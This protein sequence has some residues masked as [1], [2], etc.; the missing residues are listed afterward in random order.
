MRHRTNTFEVKA[1]RKA[2]E[3][4]PKVKARKKAYYQ[5]P[6]VKAR[7]KAY[8]QTPEARRK[9]KQYNSSKRVKL[10]RKEYAKKPKVKAYAK[11]YYQ[12]PQVV[13]NKKSYRKRD[14][15]R[16]KT[17]DYTRRPEVNI[18]IR[19]RAILNHILK[20]YTLTGKFQSSRKY[21]INFEEIIKRLKPFPAD[22]SK[23][24]IDHIRPLCNFNFIN[25][26]GTQNLEEIKKAFA[27]ENHQWLL[28]FDNLSKGSKIIVQQELRL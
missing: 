25:K 11:A 10:Y 13:K 14:Y 22:I 16:K 6:E 28:A 18:R 26:D 27:P 20:H 24:H 8:Y 2:Y 9:F 4:T 21:G 5:N 7:R 19:I 12:N 3:Q 15:V 23:Y 1:R 17:R